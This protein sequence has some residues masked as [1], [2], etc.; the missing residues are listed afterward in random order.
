MKKEYETLFIIKPHLTE[1]EYTKHVDSFK[2]WITDNEGEV[3]KLDV[4]GKKELSYE[5]NKNKLGY[6]V[7]CE[8]T[9]TNKT[10][11][12]VNRRFKV[13]ENYLRYLTIK[14]EKNAKPAVVEAE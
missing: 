5:M 4:I 2:S 9:G 6:Y 11:D 1:E 14:L 12:E 8:F 10:L 3:L 7:L 13:S